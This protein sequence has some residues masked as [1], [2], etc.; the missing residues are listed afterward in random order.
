MHPETET[1]E[2][3]EGEGRY[4]FCLHFQDPAGS[5]LHRVSPWVTRQKALRRLTKEYLRAAAVL[6]DG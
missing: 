1:D 4:V 3:Y 5:L 2:D 6:K